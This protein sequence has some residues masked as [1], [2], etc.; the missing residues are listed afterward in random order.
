[1]SKSWE[2]NIFDLQLL[3]FLRVKGFSK[4]NE[5][6]LDLL[7][8]IVIKKHSQVLGKAKQYA[9][10]NQRSEINV[11][12]VLNIIES[13]DEAIPKL[14]A[15]L[16][17]TK[18]KFSNSNTL[19]QKVVREITGETSISKNKYEEELDILNNVETVN[20]RSNYPMCFVRNKKDVEKPLYVSLPDPISIE[21]EPMMDET[22]I[23]NEEIKKQRIDETRSFELENCKVKGLEKQKE[24]NEV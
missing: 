16:V 15:H 18:D 11:F 4:V 10:N 13:N 8:D 20:L 6:A 19:I 1:M 23:P 22:V 17:K 12:D 5:K 24:N 3:E 7:K 2:E 21:H 9:Q 14:N